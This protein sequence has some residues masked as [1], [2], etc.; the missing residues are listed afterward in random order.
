[1]SSFTKPLIVE[2]V[3]EP[4]RG[5]A[6]WLPPA[7]LRQKWRTVEDFE[8]AV[9]EVENPR[10]VVMVKAGFT[11]DG[12]SVPFI[13][14]ALFPAAHPAYMQAAALHDWMYASGL[15]GRSRSDRIF[16][17]ALTVLDAPRWWAGLMY[18]AVR[19]GG[20]FFWLRRHGTME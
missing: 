2:A 4:A 7:F 3:R 6:R 18:A 15:L 10:L 9:G 12:A 19:M 20:W 1:M 13:F 16:R 14:R 17:E 11:F 5:L 8:Y